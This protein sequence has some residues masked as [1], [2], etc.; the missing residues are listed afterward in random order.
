MEMVQ[1]INNP[2]R[3]IVDYSKVYNEFIA[4][5]KATTPRERLKKRHPED[6]R[7]FCDYLY[8]ENHHIIPA[9]LGGKNTPENMVLLLPEEHIF[10][11]Y[12][13]YKAFD[14]RVDLL[15]FRYSING[16]KNHAGKIKS[17]GETPVMTRTLRNAAARLKQESAD[18][19]KRHGWQTPA[20]LKRISESRKGQIPVIDAKTGESMGSVTKDH[21][22]YISGEW[23]H[24]TKG[25]L[26]AI[27]K[28]TGEKVRIKSSDYQANK[29]LYEPNNSQVG[30]KNGRYSGLTDE[31][32]I[33]YA[34][35]YYNETRE[36]PN[37]TNL[38]RW[39]VSNGFY[40][41]RGWSKFRFGGGGRAAFYDAVEE[42][43]GVKYPRNAKG[44]RG[45]YLIQKMKNKPKDYVCKRFNKI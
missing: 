30:E 36:L 13:R 7:N 39:C 45:V 2:K 29:A 20:G 34:V 35:D 28:N 33:Q 43:L 15:A 12:L 18:F 19:R 10:I 4:H 27:D 44:E 26:T 1:T 40:M 17:I 41:I 22:K 11:H 21:P 16:I 6:P 37:L 31:T 3:T 25:W 14:T 23:V 32:I 9:S 42:C 38:Y 5:F 24:H 8:T